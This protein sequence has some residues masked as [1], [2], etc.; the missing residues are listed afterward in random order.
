MKDE[1]LNLWKWKSL[2]DSFIRD[3]DPSFQVFFNDPAMTISP[4]DKVI[5]M[6]EEMVE[7]RE[8]HLLDWKLEEDE[9]LS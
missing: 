1:Q 3:V 5:K 9:V 2:L 4:L 6:F 7:T 8:E